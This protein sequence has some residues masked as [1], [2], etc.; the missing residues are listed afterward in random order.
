M[1]QRETSIRRTD[2]APIAE[3]FEP[4]P[5]LWEGPV[6]PW[7]KWAVAI[8]VAFVVCV[9]IYGLNAPGPEPRAGGAVQSAAGSSAPASSAATTGSGAK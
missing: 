5:Y 8:A 7:A 6:R 1:A 2:E 4:D 9:V 3:P